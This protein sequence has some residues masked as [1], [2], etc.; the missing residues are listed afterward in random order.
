MRITL[1]GQQSDF[2]LNAGDAVVYPSTTL[3]EV[4]PVKAGCRRAAIT[5]IESYVRR[6]EQREMLYE[7]NAAR[8]A[9][10]NHM[11]RSPAFDQISKCHANLLREWADT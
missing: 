4:M 3:H 1:L 5:W 2:K 11:G 6:A 7:L 10:L 9:V 8:K